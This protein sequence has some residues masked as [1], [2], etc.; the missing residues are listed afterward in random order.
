MRLRKSSL[1]LIIITLLIQLLSAASLPAQAQ[2][3]RLVADEV[4]SPALAKNLLGD[5]AQRAVTVY[6]PPQ[7]DSEPPRHFPVLY[8]LHGFGGKHRFW[9]SSDRPKRPIRL[10]EMADDL[11]R[12]GNIQPLIIVMP[13]GDN[14]Y[15]GSFYLNSAVTGGWEDFVCQDLV[16]HVDSTYRTIPQASARALAGHSMGGYGALLL[17]MRHPETFRAVYG[18][19]PACL[20]FEE[21]FL[22]L[23]KANLLTVLKLTSRDQFPGLS[24]RDQVII[25]AGAAIAPN[26]NKPPFLFDLPFKEEP[27]Q[28][29]FDAAI[30]KTWLKSDPYSQLP[31][32]KEN[33]A[34]LKIAFDI[35]TADRMFPQTRLFSQSLKKLGIP[36]SYEEYDG[37]HFNRLAERLHTKVLPFLSQALHP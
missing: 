28:P 37:D 22:N 8:L 11:I 29:V 25:A 9:T 12:Q 32:L 23:Q 4:S 33:L 35:G 34:Q 27:G 17:T 5:P 21:H 18:L 15:K 30:W 16:R 24:W 2:S 10:Q 13:D 3:G 26:P 20:V 31:L 7:Y 14:A 1:L 19:S 6:L 36:H